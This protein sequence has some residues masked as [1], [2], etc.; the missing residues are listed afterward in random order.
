MIITVAIVGLLATAAFPLAELSVRRAKEQD[1]RLAL[2]SIRQGLDDYKVAADAGRIERELGDSGYPKS[3][4]ALTEGV[5]DIK[6]PEAKKIYFLRRLPR[7]PFFPDA[8]APAGQTWALRSYESPPDDPRPGDDIFDVHSTS[9]G[10]GL[11]GIPY[12]H[13]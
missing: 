2:R 6:S 13:W 9:P 8:S 5:V 4:D 1:L 7:D 10:S 11:N 3:L 12:E